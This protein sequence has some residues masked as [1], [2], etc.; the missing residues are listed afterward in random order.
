MPGPGDRRTSTSAG[1]RG[2][3]CASGN[4]TITDQVAIQAPWIWGPMPPCRIAKA[5][6]V[7]DCATPAPSNKAARSTASDTESQRSQS[8]AFSARP[9]AGC[10]QPRPQHGQRSAAVPAP[11]TGPSSTERLEN[12]NRDSRSERTSWFGSSDGVAE[13][14][15]PAHELLHLL[16]LQHQRMAMTTAGEEE[17]S[18]RRCHVLKHISIELAETPPVVGDRCTAAEIANGHHNGGFTERVTE[19]LHR[20]SDP[21]RSPASPVGVH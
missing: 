18:I 10:G 4:K 6:P 20:R 16:L 21:H 3:T 14:Q 13:S 2:Q 15:R 17:S 1:S 5:R 8:P 12:G 11:L 9:T 7:D 19:L